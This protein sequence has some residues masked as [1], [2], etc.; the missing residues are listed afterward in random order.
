MT[1]LVRLSSRAAWLDEDN[2]DTDAILPARFLLLFEK[3][4]FGRH[5]F[6]DR[7]HG[8]DGAPRPGF[9][10]DRPD[11]AGAEILLG[12]HNFGC[13]SSREH[14]VW[15]LAGHGIRCVI[16]ISF[17]DIFRTNCIKNGLLPVTIPARD[18]PA[19]LAAAE[20]G[21]IFDVDLRA[22][23]L[24]AA[25]RDWPVEL[26]REDRESL[27]NGWDEVERIVHLHGADIAA[28][29]AAHRAAQPW[30]FADDR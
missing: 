15:A 23:R 28:F 8:P 13:G 18:H 24:R 9:P 11:R 14:A 30:L 4:Q 7:R 25:G 16:A 1:P 20:R 26:S 29:E 6:H 5:L 2:V 10:L 27:L 3:S 21:E 19:L 12:R 22:G 17:G